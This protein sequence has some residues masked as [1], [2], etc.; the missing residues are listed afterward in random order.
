MGNALAIGE[1]VLQ[2]GLKALWEFALPFWSVNG[3]LRRLY[4]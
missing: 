1:N 3:D 2:G 4:C